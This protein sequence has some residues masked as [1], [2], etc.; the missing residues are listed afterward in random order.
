MLKP[1]TRQ[2]LRYWETLSDDQLL[3]AEL[4]TDD[5][6]GLDNVVYKLPEGD[7]EPY[8]EYKYD[9]RGSD[10]QML[11]CVH[12]NH[13]HLAG[14]VMRKANHRFFVG[15]ICGER[16]YGE[17]FEQYTADFDAAVNR[18]DALKRTQE[19]KRATRPVT[20]WLDGVS[21]SE[22]FE[23]YS[24]VRERMREQLPWIFENVPRA[25]AS[26]PH[27]SA[28]FPHT[29]FSEGAD[30]E[31]EFNKAASEFNTAVLT[32]ITKPDLN[33]NQV[34]RHFNVLSKRIEAALDQLEEVV[35]FF[36]PRVLAFICDLA[37][38]FDNPRKRQYE[39]GLMSITCKR[40]RNTVI[41]Q[42]PKHYKVPNRDVINNFRTEL[43]G[44]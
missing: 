10:R 22:V 31:L 4:T 6:E 24:L 29:L 43:D 16:I 39:P 17:N 18:Q 15:H 30:P 3:A 42:V 23:C 2:S 35:D 28:R 1:K 20:E 27:A 34:K 33:I 11:R 36:Q 40:Q 14:F 44:L 37:N 38:Q 8:V 5:P 25:A 21:Q 7:E 13:P 41:V 19:A 26:Y 9:L 12:G 32:L